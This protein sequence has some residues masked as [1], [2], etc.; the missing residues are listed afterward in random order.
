MEY[1]ENG[2]ESGPGG[3]LFWNAPK[4]KEKRVREFLEGY[5]LSSLVRTVY[6][7]AG[8]RTVLSLHLDADMARDIAPGYDTLGLSARLRL[9]SEKSRAGL[10]KEI[11]LALLMSPQPVPFPSLEE[12]ISAISLR[13]HIVEAARCTSVAF[14]TEAAERPAGYFEYHE[15]CGFCLC[16]GKSLIDA[17]LKATQ[18]DISGTRYSFSCYRASEYILLLSIAME[19]QERNPDAYATLESIWHTRAIMSGEFH[20]VFLRE[21]G[22]LNRPLPLRYFVPG[23]RVWF[24]NPDER[25]ADVAGYE[26]SWVF[27]LGNGLFCNF[28]KHEQPYTLKHKCLEIYHWR[29]G[30]YMDDGGKLRMDENEVEARVAATLRDED[31][32]ARILAL[33]MRPREPRGVYRDGG[34][35][36]VSREFPRWICRKTADIRL[37]AH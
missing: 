20:A 13:T 23:D 28:W 5:G 10:E 24:R 14:D 22:S 17:L 30:A 26:G 36:D 1:S 32:T 35:M 33:M 16:H 21:F 37:P 34:C 19:L 18:P 9:A 29:H 15:G 4:G 2:P 27:Y 8:G 7:N 12:L 11:L 3:I 6:E 25:S 31:E